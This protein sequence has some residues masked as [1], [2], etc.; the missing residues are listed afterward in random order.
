MSARPVEFKAGMES[1]DLE[2]INSMLDAF[3]QG[4]YF[5]AKFRRD[6]EKTRKYCEGL[7]R[8]LRTI[9]RTN[10]Y[11]EGVDKYIADL[12]RTRDMSRTYLHLDMDAYYAHVEENDNPSLKGKPVAVGSMD[13]LVT[14]NYVARKYGI[15]SGIPGVLALKI[16]PSLIILPQRMD[17]YRE[18][19]A[20]IRNQM[21]LFDENF[22]SPSLDEGCVDITNV[23]KDNPSL[24]STDIAKLLQQ[25]ILENTNLTCS[26]GVAP[27][28]L[29]AKMC[30]ETN[31]PNGYFVLDKDP[32]KCK[33]FVSTISG[34]GK[35]RHRLL[36]MLG[37]NNVEDVLENKYDLFYILPETH[38]D[39]LFKHALCIPI[40][41]QSTQ[42]FLLRKRTQISKEK[43]CK[44]IYDEND[45][46]DLL[47][48]MY[49]DAIKML[50]NEQKI[51][52]G[53]VVKMTDFKL[54][55]QN[56]PFSLHSAVPA[57]VID[58]DGFIVRN[59]DDPTPNDL[60]PENE[61]T[62]QDNCL[63]IRQNFF[64]VAKT[65]LQWAQVRSVGLRLVNLYELE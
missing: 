10:D 30:S 58:Q 43:S 50:Y 37:L 44:E 6:E 54:N 4:S 55:V 23:L 35:T 12:E 42:Y 17:R 47:E 15:R 21:Q 8:K 29:L 38:R 18:V 63:F 41:P 22:I 32:K 1:V 39:L 19:S 65:A 53:M 27:S 46:N 60:V 31:K 16:C 62:F 34:L 57:P 45:L 52:Y 26:M 7:L 28:P 61:I 3:S 59:K 49:L 48:N 40:P 2:M 51:A 20:I 9:P 56:Y 14:S 5:Q 33:E 64:T 11:F 25:K 24:K 36:E 13:M